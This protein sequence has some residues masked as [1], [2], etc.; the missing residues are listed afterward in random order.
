L[1]VILPNRC[2]QPLQHRL[3]DQAQISRTP[4]SWNLLPDNTEV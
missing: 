2:I 3:L 1:M 4:H